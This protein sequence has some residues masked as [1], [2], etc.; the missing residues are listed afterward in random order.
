MYR[1]ITHEATYLPAAILHLLLLSTSTALRS[2]RRLTPSP[3]QAVAVCVCLH[4]LLSLISAF[5]LIETA[6]QLWT[7]YR[8]HATR[9][10]LCSPRIEPPFRFA[11]LTVRVLS[12]RRDKSLKYNNTESS[13][14]V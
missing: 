2:V 1:S 9:A 14:Q 11:L 7:V 3:Q 12:G 5:I 8:Q 4:V 13:D 6:V 10:Q